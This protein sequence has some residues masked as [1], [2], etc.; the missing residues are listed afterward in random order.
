MNSQPV[1]RAASTSL[2][3]SAIRIRTLGS[4][5]KILE[6]RSRAAWGRDRTDQ[7]ALMRAAWQGHAEIV[8]LLV[9][10]GADVNAKSDLGLTV[11][12]GA[13]KHGHTA[14]VEMLKK[15]GAKD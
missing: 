9:E 1:A 6:K 5:P 13:A 8:N 7:T 10:R 11:L 3:V 2:G 14:V 15:V 4:A 12:M